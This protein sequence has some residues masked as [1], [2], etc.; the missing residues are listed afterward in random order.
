MNDNNT[1]YNDFGTW[2]RSQFPF[3]VQKISINA[4]LS[5][6]NRDGSIGR[7]GCIYCDNR[8]FNPSYC[9]TGRSIR[10]QIEAG[11]EFFARKYPDMKYLAYFQA[12]TN[13]YGSVERLKRM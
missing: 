7:G 9:D 10:S 11:K 8:T 6:P 1:P 12:Y 5:C 2:L 13:T 3:R 4:G